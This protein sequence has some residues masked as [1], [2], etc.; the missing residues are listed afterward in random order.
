MFV[1]VPMEER[2][3]TPTDVAE[4]PSLELA[5]QFVQPSYDIVLR[6]MDSAE[7]RARASLGFAGTLMVAAP[8]FVAATLGPANRSFVWPWFL[9]G[10]LAFIGVLGCVIGQQ[11]PKIVGG[12]VRVIAP[13]GLVNQGWVHASPS[14]FRWNILLWAAN[15]WDTN[16]VILSRVANMASVAAGLVG[17]QAIALAIWALGY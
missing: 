5:Y 1:L 6:R 14:E 10:A 11:I 9:L 15:N 16:R 3:A 2:G 12:D 4:S 13:G 7:A 17:V 8:A